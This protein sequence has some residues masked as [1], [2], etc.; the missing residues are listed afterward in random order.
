MSNTASIDIDS[1]E[2]F[3]AFIKN[4]YSPLTIYRGQPEDKPLPQKIG[5]IKLTA[6]LLEAE[7]DMLELFKEQSIPFL[8]KSPVFDRDWLALAQ[9][10]GLPT[11]LLD[12]TLN[13]LIALWF[14]VEKPPKDNESG[15]VWVFKFEKSDLAKGNFNPFSIKSTKIF[16]PPHI[17]ARIRAQ[18]GF[19]TAHAISKNGSFVR[20]ENNNKYKD[21]LKKIAI[22]PEKFSFIRHDLDILGINRSSVYSDLDGLAQ[23]LGW[24][25]QLLDDETSKPVPVL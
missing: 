22:P 19:F 8:P 3:V 12:W 2:S 11:R 21:R 7:N 17:V 23:H 15:V 14:T 16:R 9:H 25:Y 6:S 20:L 13:P 4:D 5:R 24:L 1:L 10:H 18:S